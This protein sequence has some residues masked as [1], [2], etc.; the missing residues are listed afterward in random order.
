[1][2][3]HC[4]LDPLKETCEKFF[5]IWSHKAANLSNELIEYTIRR[6]QIDRLRFLFQTRNEVTQR[7]VA[8]PLCQI[9]THTENDMQRLKEHIRRFCLTTRN[10]YRHLRSDSRLYPAMTIALDQGI[11]IKICRFIF[12][13]KVLIKIFAKEQHLSEHRPRP[14]DQADLN[15]PY[16][17]I[18]KAFVVLQSNFQILFGDVVDRDFF[19]NAKTGTRVS[20]H[21]LL[22]SISIRE[23]VEERHD[24]PVG[25]NRFFRSA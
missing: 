21:H 9:P 13:T 22:T 19:Q 16:K 25:S 10:V 15:D 24:F 7:T 20:E 5:Q 4:P 1:M 11:M 17:N 3:G 14:A 18:S 8:A 12:K 23:E 2:T 6:M